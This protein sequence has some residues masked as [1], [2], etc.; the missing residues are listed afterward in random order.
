MHKT[1]DR[2]TRIPLKTE[3]DSG[4]PEEWTVS[5]PLMTIIHVHAYY[6][7]MIYIYT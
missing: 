7:T 5:A 2:V 3:G 1:K 4:A 6:K